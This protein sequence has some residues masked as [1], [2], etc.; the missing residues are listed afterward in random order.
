MQQKGKTNNFSALLY[1]TTEKIDIDIGTGL[2]PDQ[3]SWV[4]FCPGQVG[5]IPVFGS[6]LDSALDQVH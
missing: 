4:M 3:L 6:D 2:K 5:L 1:P